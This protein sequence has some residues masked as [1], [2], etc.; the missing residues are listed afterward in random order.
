[1][2]HYCIFKGT[3]S[4]DLDLMMEKCPPKV[5]AAPRYTS[6]TVPGRNGTLTQADGSYDVFTR[7]AEFVV[8]DPQR[9]PE[10][11]AMFS[12]NGDLAF[13]DEPDKKYSARIKEGFSFSQEA[14]LTNRFAVPFECQPFARER[15]PQT[16]VFTAAGSLYNIGTFEAQP[17][18]KVF[19]SGNITVTV[20]GKAFTVQNVPGSAAIDCENMLAC[21]GSTLLVTSGEYPI[22]PAGKS[23]ISFTGATKIEVTP[24][25]R[26][27]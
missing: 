20:N 8:F 17:T 23:T 13:D 26:W 16:A 11:M 4:L 19:G 18:I 1:M 21:S 15:Y 2:Q 6:V 7:Q 27:L 10:I 12:G 14:L 25:W 9:W 5:H 24:N 22:L 3:N